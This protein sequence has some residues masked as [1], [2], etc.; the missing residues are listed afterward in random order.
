M[1]LSYNQLE[2]Q[3]TPYSESLFL[4]WVPWDKKTKTIFYLASRS[5]CDDRFINC[6]FPLTYSKVRRVAYFGVKDWYVL[7]QALPQPFFFEKQGEQQGRRHSAWNLQTVTCV[8]YC[9]SILY[10]SG[11]LHQHEWLVIFLERVGQPIGVWVLR[12]Q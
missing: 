5:Y 2:V 7:R 4:I 10:L 12:T 11:K 8:S 1:L 9:A 3:T 6:T